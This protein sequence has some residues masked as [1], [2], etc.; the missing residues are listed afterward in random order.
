MMPI[1]PFPVAQGVAGIVPIIHGDGRWVIF[2]KHE[3]LP[4]RN[5]AAILPASMVWARHAF[6][7]RDWSKGSASHGNAKVI[8]SLAPGVPTHGKDDNGN[9]TV[10]A[11]ALEFLGLL[12]DIAS[13]DSPVGIKPNG[14]TVDYLVNSSKAWEVWERLMGNAERAA[15]RIY[16]GT[17]GTL[18]A[19]GGAPGVDIQALFGVARTRVEG[20]LACISSALLT[21][22]IEPWC[23]V[24]FGDSSQAPRREYAIP[25][26]DA[27]AAAE[28]FQKRSA[29]FWADI[30]NALQTQ[31]GPLDP[32]YV[33]DLAKRYGVPVPKFTGRA[34]EPDG[35]VAQVQRAA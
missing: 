7:A 11:D 2:K 21:G 23:A 17:D 20:D 5:E 16:L 10:T 35:S 14:A 1:D 25:D 18:G 27:D 34:V 30:H 32:E 13:L 29:A 31:S 15:A 33:E 8:G 6:A 4:W 19:V 3:I 24:N 12:E 9:V 28:S 26:S 22:V